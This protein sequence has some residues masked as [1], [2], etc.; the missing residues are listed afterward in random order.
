[1]LLLNISAN[2]SLAI[3]FSAIFDANGAA[4]NGRYNENNNV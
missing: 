2:R 4:T 3:H 1:M